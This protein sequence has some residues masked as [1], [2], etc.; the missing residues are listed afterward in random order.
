MWSEH[1]D[2]NRCVL[3]VDVALSQTQTAGGIDFAGLSAPISHGAAGNA[4]IFH[5]KAWLRP[6]PL[7]GRLGVT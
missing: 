7:G 5:A 2:I 3:V 6:A 1:G 4:I